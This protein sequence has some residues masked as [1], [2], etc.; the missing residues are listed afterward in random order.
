VIDRTN[1]RLT[2][3][4]PQLMTI[5]QAA[6]SLS[7]SKRMVQT[8]VAAGKIRTVLIGAR[9]RRIDARDLASYVESRRGR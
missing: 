6:E 5:E 2:M 3:T 9:C 8:L 7:V 4:V 1:Q